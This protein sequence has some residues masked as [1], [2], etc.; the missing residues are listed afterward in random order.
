MNPTMTPSS[1]VSYNSLEYN[2]TDLQYPIDLS[3]S[4][5]YGGHRVIFMINVNSDSK[6]MRNNAYGSRS[7]ADIPTS[8]VKRTA[9]EE[10]TNRLIGVVNTNTSADI[11]IGTPYKRLLGAISLY[12]PN[13]L[14]ISYGTNWGE[15]DLAMS[16]AAA[17]LVMSALPGQNDKGTTFS[18]TGA[19]VGAAKVLGQF[20]SLQRA[21]KTTPKNTKVAQLFQ[22][23]DFRTVQFN[24]DFAPRN[25]AEAENVLNIVRMFRHHM[26]P[27]FKDEVQFLYLYPSEFEIKYFKGDKE[28]EYLE[29]HFTAVLTNCSI[30][31]TPDGI[32]S[33]FENGMPSR[34]RMALAFKE[35]SKPTKDTSPYNR[36][37]T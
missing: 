16:E 22:G 2:I 3:A 31:Y 1:T 6:L 24:Y 12:I 23:V 17:E 14:T 36:S 37:G 29:K 11:K 21:T 27:E 10:A 15:D 8:E 13:D 26:L 30:T 28:N 32:F 7:V 20:E 5:S 34:L 35:L 18:G 19:S 25:I 9:L 33:S 4:E